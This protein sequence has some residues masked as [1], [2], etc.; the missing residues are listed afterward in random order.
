M[1]G[2]LTITKWSLFFYSSN[3]QPLPT[4]FINPMNQATGPD[5]LIILQR[6]HD[7][8]EVG[9]HLTTLAAPSVARAKLKI[10][11]VI[12]GELDW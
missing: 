4:P 5:M 1:S 6:G 10:S 11:G 2:L 3:H 7:P 12:S 9:R 8:G